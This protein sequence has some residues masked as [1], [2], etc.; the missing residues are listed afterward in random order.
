[1][2]KKMAVAI[3][4]AHIFLAIMAG[5]MLLA[6]GIQL[7]RQDYRDHL[8]QARADTAEDAKSALMAL[9]SRIFA[10]ELVANR[11]A[12]FIA[13]SPDIPENLVAD[14]AAKLVERHPEI[15][16]IALAPGLRVSHVAPRRGNE[17]VLGLD[18]RDVPNQLASVAR[19][20]RDG[21]PVLTGPTELVQGG[22]G[23]V[24]RYP[25]FVPSV[26]F[27]APSASFDSSQ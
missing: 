11:L 20:Y 17:A 13:V 3:S 16:S 10:M 26:S 23:Y 6:F 21:A 27:A 25:V 5:V 19:A 14:T 7:V 4:R 9:E 2:K 1:M 12:T 22:R 8:H 18:Y 24:L 15:K